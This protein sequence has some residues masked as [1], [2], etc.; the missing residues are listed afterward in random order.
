MPPKFDPNVDIRQ[1][2]MDFTFDDD[3]EARSKSELLEQIPP[4]LRDNWADGGSCDQAISVRVAG[5]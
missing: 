4:L 1:G 5:Q 3:A 2:M